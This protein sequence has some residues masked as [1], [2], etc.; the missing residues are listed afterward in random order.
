MT[1]G[2]VS[3]TPAPPARLSRHGWVV[4]LLLF[5]AA[6]LN[7]VDRGSLSVAAPQLAPE[8]KLDPVHVGLLL[9]AFFW[10]YSV[11]QMIAG[12]LV[13]RYPVY[14][15]FAI[16]F[17]LWSVATLASGIV[18]TL[19]WLFALRLLLGVGESV[20]FPCYSKVIT[21]QFPPERRGL[22]N[23]LLDAGTKLGPS[24]G[25][26]FGGLI[27]ATYGWRAMFLV[28]GA[29]SL[30]W[31]IPWLVWAPRP[32]TQLDCQGSVIHDMSSPD[33]ILVGETDPRAGAILEEM[34]RGVLQDL[35]GELLYR[36]HLPRLLQMAV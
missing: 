18:S 22:P 9:S 21:A 35:T 12:W 14:W 10:S 15:V 32:A 25:T 5:F 1:M 28:L 23:A 29:G 13:D 6:M 33:M 11:C 7:Y 31:L 16:G 27:A 30:L 24:V 2:A 34:Y 3:E 17:L 36:V 20:A 26:F 19:G 8:L 4:V